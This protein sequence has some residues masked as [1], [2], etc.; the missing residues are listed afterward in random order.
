MNGQVLDVDGTPV[1]VTHLDKV[2]YPATGTTKAAV[3]DYVVQ[4]APA[5]LAQLRDRPVTRMRW[6][7]GTGAERFVEKNVPRGAPDWLRHRV[8][9]ASPGEVDEG[10]RLDLP[11]LDGLPGLVWAANG[12]ALELHTPQWRVGPR[13][14]VRPPDRLV[15][16]LDPGPPAGLDECATVAHLVAERL[17]ADGLTGTVPVTSGSKGMQLYAPLPGRR[18]ATQVRAYARDLATAV[19]AE[20]PELVV[21][22]MRRS[23]RPGKVLIDWS[24]NHPAKTT[25]TPYSLRGREAPTVAAPRWWDEIGPGLTQ[26]TMDE[27]VR[28]LR[29]D[30]DPFA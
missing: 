22:V 4:V 5:L 20:H 1:R 15:V 17:A 29:D 13:G 24:Q 14:R 23:L 2:L 6:P 12:G 28:R 16:D 9:P 25:I 18:P 11:F 27:V 3:I 8:L 21:A 10:T 30:G 7:E 26:L 19:A